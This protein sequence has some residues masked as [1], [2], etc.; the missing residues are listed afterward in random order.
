MSL[1]PAVE[2][3]QGDWPCS[4]CWEHVVQ[5]VLSYPKQVH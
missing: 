2:K 1:L 3:L 4:N 5:P